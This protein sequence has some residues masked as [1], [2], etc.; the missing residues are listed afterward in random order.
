MEVRDI[1]FVGARVVAAAG[2][3][4]R[5]TAI[6]GGHSVTA[7]DGSF[8]L[9]VGGLLE[10]GDVVTWR[11]PRT[12]ATIR[13]HCRIHGGRGGLG[14]SGV[15]V[16]GRGQ[17]RTTVPPAPTR[18]VPS[19]RY[20]TLARAL[21][22]APR[23]TTVVVRPGVYRESLVVT[24][25][26]ITI[27]GAGTRPADVVL[28]GSIGRDVGITVIADDVRLERIALRRF[29]VAG[30]HAH[31]TRGFSARELELRAN[32]SYGV[33]LE[34]VTDVLLDRVYAGG[35]AVAGVSVAECSCDAV[36]KGAIAE[37][38]LAG[39]VI[40]NAASVV[41]RDSIIR[42]NA[43][44]VVL[45]TT[46]GDP[47]LQQR[48]AALLRNS[49]TDNVA[50]TVPVAP[51]SADLDLPVGTGVL[52]LGGRDNVISRNTVTGHHFGIAVVASTL[53]ASGNRVTENLVSDS[54]TADLAWDGVGTGTCFAANSRTDGGQPQ[55]EPALA[56]RLYACSLLV[57]I[58]LP[59]PLIATQLAQY[60]VTRHYCRQLLGS[61]C[62]TAARATVR[63]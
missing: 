47:A 6:D 16:V 49:I 5:W 23:G 8:D 29:G 35:S 39:I 62:P 26:G 20:P 33:R 54:T 38:N 2:A 43:V 48:A 34:R 28:D 37:R 11:A 13:Y 18:L 27:R 19:R 3:T 15:V 55:S 59:D 9:P 22:S 31:D 57:T 58:G 1:E 10:P 14:M 51:L 41:V 42:A 25:P 17:P 7:D 12:D 53:P 61:A 46:R 21:T 30:I 60:A 40:S 45:K 32:G 44:G 36:I 4:V 56:Q 63:R 24:T 50:L 52:V